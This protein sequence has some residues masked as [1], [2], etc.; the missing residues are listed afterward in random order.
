M[1]LGSVL[2]TA[3]S[4]IAAATASVDAASNNLANM[5]TNGFKATKPVVAEQAPTTESIGSAPSEFEGGANPRQAGTGVR[6][7]GY[8]TDDSPGPLVVEQDADGNDVLVEL[9]NTDVGENLVELIL[10]GDQ[11]RANAAVFDTAG[12]LLDELI[13]LGRARD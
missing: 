11:L 7:V 10:A 3:L 4:G 9:S 13:H 1:P 5:R 2:Q 6:V 8:R 12:A